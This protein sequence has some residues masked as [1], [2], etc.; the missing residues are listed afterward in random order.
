MFLMLCYPKDFGMHQDDSRLSAERR[1][2][3]YTMPNRKHSSSFHVL[4]AASDMLWYYSVTGLSD[5]SSGC[6]G[7]GA[8]PSPMSLLKPKGHALVSLWPTFRLHI[9]TYQGGERLASPSV[10]IPAFSSAW[11]KW[12]DGY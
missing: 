3:A 6:G 10:D 1:A 8:Y 7:P 4:M 12:N 11:Y 9:S 5:L 2:P